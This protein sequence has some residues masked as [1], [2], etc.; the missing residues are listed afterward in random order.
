MQKKDSKAKFCVKCRGNFLSEQ[1]AAKMVESSELRMAEPKKVE[2]TVKIKVEPV[3]PLNIERSVK[4]AKS[5]YTEDIEKA[6]VSLYHGLSVIE[7]D[8]SNASRSDDV[9]RYATFMRN[10]ISTIQALDDL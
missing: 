10:V 6:R 9:D 2:E 1:D 7:K 3:E 8:L 5:D 4:K